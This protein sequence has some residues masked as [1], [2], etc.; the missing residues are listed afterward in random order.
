MKFDWFPSQLQIVVE[1]HSIQHRLKH[2]I[3]HWGVEYVRK[4]VEKLLTNIGLRKNCT[5]SDY[6]PPL[7][8]ARSPLVGI[9]VNFTLIRIQEIM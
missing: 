7:S 8:C 9:L 6:P 2:A 3:L 4:N 1:D 5:I